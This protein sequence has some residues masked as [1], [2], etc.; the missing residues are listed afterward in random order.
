MDFLGKIRTKF[1]ADF[2]TLPTVNDN[3][4]ASYGSDVLWCRLTILFGNNP[5]VS[6]GGT[7]NHARMTNV[8]VVQLFSP[9]GQGDGAAITK[10]KEIINKFSAY[11]DGTL[12]C[13]TGYMQRIGLRDD[14]YQ[15]N[16]NV[17]FTV[18]NTI[19][20]MK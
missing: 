20:D 7:T 6:N 3:Q 10:A 1:A 15:I 4:V 18:D 14:R 19:G 16:V 8:M 17:L 13:Q 9:V 2:A 11:R 12:R 5:R